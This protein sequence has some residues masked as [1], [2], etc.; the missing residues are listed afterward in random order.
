MKRPP[1]GLGPIF[2]LD[3]RLALPL[4]AQI[5]AGYRGAILDGRLRPGQ[6]L[7]STR[8]LARDLAISRI[9]VVTAFQQL[10]A[11]GYVDGRVGAGT[12]VS[13]ALPAPPPRAAARDA[14]HCVVA[15]A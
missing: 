9:P 11:E 2:A 14:A 10:L 12:F 8:S 13:T 3:R 7:P 4:Y 1:D 5:Y 6:R 15:G